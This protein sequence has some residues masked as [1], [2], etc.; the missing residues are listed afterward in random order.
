[1][2]VNRKIRVEY[3]RVAC[4]KKGDQPNSRDRLFDL[5]AWLEKAESKSLE[6]RTYDYYDEQARLDKF[7]SL[8]GD[9][10]FLSFLRLRETNIPSRAWK[11]RESEPMELDDDEFIGENAC[12]VFDGD[13]NILMLQR[14]RH[15]LGVNGIEEYLN[16][17]WASDTEEIYLRSIPPGDLIKKA[18]GAHEYRRITVRFADIQKNQDAGSGLRGTLKQAFNLFTKYQ[19]VSGEITITMGHTRGDSLHKETIRDSIDDIRDNQDLIVKAEVGFKESDDTAVEVLDLFS[20]RIHSFIYVTLE[21]RESL[22]DEMMSTSMLKQYNV[23]RP[24]LLEVIEGS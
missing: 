23:M 8:P 7:W 11:D 4:K 13:L 18:K 24:K 16:L 10:L 6:A 1:M 12:A 3:Y 15:S 19:G 21:K 14:N 9:L 2:A 17:L 5:H 20:D 22:S